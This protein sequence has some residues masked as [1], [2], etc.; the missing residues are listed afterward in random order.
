MTYLTVKPNRNGLS[1][2]FDSFIGDMFSLPA[3]RSM[4]DADGDF[5]PRVNVHE[6]KDS[7]ALTF[8]LPGMKKDDIKVTVQ[9][10][11][12]TVSGRREFKSEDKDGDYVRC[13][14]RSGSFSR[15]FTLPDSVDAEKIKADYKDGLLEVSLARREE[16][17]PKEIEVKVS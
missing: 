2:V 14:I 8:E 16:L 9:D 12:L 6:S 13:E 5:S 17:K 15:S 3:V 4:A 11:N 1:R 10:G 7:V